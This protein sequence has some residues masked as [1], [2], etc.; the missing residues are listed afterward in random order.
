MD[1]YVEPT[2]SLSQAPD[3]N[4]STSGTSPPGI[5]CKF[6]KEYLKKNIE[7]IINRKI[8]NN[9]NTINNNSANININLNIDSIPDL[10]INKISKI[11]KIYNINYFYESLLLTIHKYKLFII[12]IIVLIFFYI[13]LQ[14][15]LFSNK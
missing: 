11:Y 3:S 1:S 7:L 5:R 12:I 15:H 6:F 4:G 10:S 13:Y 2:R 9:N 8:K 14:K